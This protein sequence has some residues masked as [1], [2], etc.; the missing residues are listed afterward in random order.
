MIHSKESNDVHRL[1][2]HSTYREKKREWECI[3]HE[4]KRTEKVNYWK[5]NCMFVLRVWSSMKTRFWKMLWFKQLQKNCDTLL[6]L[7]LLLPF[8]YGAKCDLYTC[9]CLYCEINVFICE[10][11]ART[12]EQTHSITVW[13]NQKQYEKR[14]PL[15][16]TKN[17]PNH[18]QWQQ[19]NSNH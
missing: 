12:H 8:A 13:H 16:S 3:W 14:F 19:L 17:V 5:F 7:L 4:H 11:Q 18:C 15:Q 10:F 6:L 1:T 9:V 2:A